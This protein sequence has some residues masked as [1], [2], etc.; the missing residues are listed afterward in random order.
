MILYAH[1]QTQ[2]I[3]PNYLKTVLTVRD[4]TLAKA[5]TACAALGPG[6]GG[7]SMP[8]QIVNACSKTSGG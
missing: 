5:Q 7:V 2:A 6:C 4:Y 8:G 1:Q 3:Q